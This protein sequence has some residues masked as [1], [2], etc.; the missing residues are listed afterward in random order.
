[1]FFTRFSFFNPYAVDGGAGVLGALRQRRLAFPI[2]WTNQPGKTLRHS[3]FMLMML[4]PCFCA[5]FRAFS[6]PLELPAARQ[7]FFKL[8]P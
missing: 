4:Q 2:H 3:R 7:R 1:M 8:V 6:S 5:A